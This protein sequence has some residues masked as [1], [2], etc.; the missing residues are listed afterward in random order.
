MTEFWP[1]N[2]TGKTKVWPVKYT[3]SPDI[4][5]WPAVISSPVHWSCSTSIAMF[6]NVS[7]YYSDRLQNGIFDD[8]AMLTNFM[9]GKVLSVIL[10]WYEKI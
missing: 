1:V 9:V 10:I 6:L 4:V 7:F 5:C 2:M 8:E 3:I